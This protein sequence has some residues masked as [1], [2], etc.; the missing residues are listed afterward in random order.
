MAKKV[1]V[2][3]CYGPPEYV[4]RTEKGQLLRRNQ[5]TLKLVQTDEVLPTEEESEDEKIGEEEHEEQAEGVKEEEDSLEAPE[6]EQKNEDIFG[7]CTSI[8]NMMPSI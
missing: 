5:W 7:L 4:V 3:Q 1:V 2:H 8:T 6:K